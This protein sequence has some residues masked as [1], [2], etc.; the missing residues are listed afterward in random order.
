MERDYYPSDLELA[1]RLFPDIPFEDAAYKL[2]DIG[3]ERAG[4]SCLYLAAI[5][6]KMSVDAVVLDVAEYFADRE[7]GLR[8]GQRPFHPATLE[9]CGLR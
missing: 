3:E 5:E 6:S 1:N 7:I 2:L 8:T 9:R 4:K